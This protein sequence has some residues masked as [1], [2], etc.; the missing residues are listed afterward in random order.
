MNEELFFSLMIDLHRDGER[1][2]PGSEEDTLRALALTQLDTL[3]SLKVADIG[4]GTGASSLVL[5]KHLP[6]SKITAVDLFS[7]F[8]DVL[9]ERALNAGVANK[10]DMRIKFNTNQEIFVKTP[11]GKPTNIVE[12]IQP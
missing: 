12:H 8:L 1:Q 7:D 4:C 10:I 5:A 3:S 11:I 2:G 6:N 9:S